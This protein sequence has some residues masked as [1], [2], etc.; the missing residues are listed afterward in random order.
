M[1]ENILAGRAKG[2]ENAG[3]QP[4]GTGTRWR[5]TGACSRGDECRKR[6]IHDYKNQLNCI[7]G[8]VDDNRT[9]E[10]LRYIGQLTGSLTKAFIRLIQAIRW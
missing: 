10:A 7:R 3:C 1:M 5:F 6:Q 9:K 4:R 2:G 8:L